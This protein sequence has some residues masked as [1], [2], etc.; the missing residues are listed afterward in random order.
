MIIVH[1][2]MPINPAKKAEVESRG[3]EFAATCRAEEGAVDY[4]LSWKFGEPATLQLVEHWDTLEAY[5][6]HTTQPHVHD[7]AAWIPGQ[8]AGALEVGRYHVEPVE[9]QGF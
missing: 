2:E 1:A 8:A 4:Q 3:A 7:W 9:P 6:T 5:K